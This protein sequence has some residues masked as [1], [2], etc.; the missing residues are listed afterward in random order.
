MNAA[1][2]VRIRGENTFITA[3]RAVETTYLLVNRFN[4]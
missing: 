3:G 1:A 4:T 2:N